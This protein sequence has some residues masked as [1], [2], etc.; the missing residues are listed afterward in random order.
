MR[1]SDWSSDVCSSDLAVAQAVVVEHAELVQDD[2]V[3]HRA[4]QAQVALAHVLQVAH[5]AEGAGSADLADVVLGREL[6]LGPRLRL[7]D[8]RLVEIDGEAQAEAGMRIEAGYLVAVAH[9]HRATGRETV[10]TPV[11]NT[12]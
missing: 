6:D 5:E 9:F 2:R 4:A 12:N 3:V 7:G 10:R 1:I 11:T 8:R